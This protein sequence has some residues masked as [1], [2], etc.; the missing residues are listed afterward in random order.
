MRGRGNRSDSAGAGPT[1]VRTVKLHRIEV[2]ANPRADG[3]FAE[4]AQAHADDGAD[5]PEELQR[6][7]REYWPD[8]R[9]ARGITDG[10]SERWYA[11]REGHWI[12]S[13]ETG[14]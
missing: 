5:D 10:N 13:G 6:R 14:A 12:D 4:A 11:Y 2:F 3:A 1:L 9:V 7:L 8:S